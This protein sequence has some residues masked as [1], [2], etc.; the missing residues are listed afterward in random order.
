MEHKPT[1]RWAWNERWRIVK[2]D[3]P[4]MRLFI[5]GKGAY[6]WD[7]KQPP[8]RPAYAQNDPSYKDETYSDEFD[9]GVALALAALL[10]ES[11]DEAAVAEPATE[12]PPAWITATLI[13]VG[14][15]V[16]WTV[17]AWI[18]DGNISQD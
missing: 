14:G 9:R 17:A 16:F 10:S 1:T 12:S 13:I 11:R 8:T 18:F 5:N 6:C 2:K 3:D 4:G 7:T 15:L